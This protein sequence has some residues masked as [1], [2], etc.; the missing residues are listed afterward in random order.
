MPSV[1]AVVNSPR[2][3]PGSDAPA[4]SINPIDCAANC[5]GVHAAINDIYDH[6]YPP[7]GSRRAAS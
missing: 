2:K 1:G 7:G 6:A 5:A 4:L 3:P